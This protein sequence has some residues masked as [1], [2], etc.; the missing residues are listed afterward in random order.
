MA[1]PLYPPSSRELF[2]IFQGPTRQVSQYT[3]TDRMPPGVRGAGRKWAN[4]E[5]G[6]PVRRRGKA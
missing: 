5:I 6:G 2:E 4:K 1:E 3:S